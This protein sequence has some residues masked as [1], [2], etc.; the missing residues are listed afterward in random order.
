M[1]DGRGALGT[2]L[3]TE[4][5]REVL[6]VVQAQLGADRV[7]GWEVGPRH[8]GGPLEIEVAAG[9]GLVFLEADQRF[10]KRIF[11]QAGPLAAGPT[12]DGCWPGGAGHEG[13]VVPFLPP[14]D[15]E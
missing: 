8:P 10:E 4:V 7:G 6:D 15:S 2:P 14:G 3:E 1:Q 9:N 11:K 13:D 5:K 12:H